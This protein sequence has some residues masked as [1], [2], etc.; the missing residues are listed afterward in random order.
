[1]YYSPSRKS[2]LPGVF[3]SAALC[4]F[5]S[6][7]AY[8]AAGEFQVPSQLFSESA[9]QAR[10]LVTRVGDT[11]GEVAVDYATEDETAQAG[12]DYQ[13]ASG[14]LT[15]LT[16]ETNQFFSVPLFNNSL[17]DSNRAFIVVLK[18]PQT[19]D[20][21]GGTNVNRIW[22]LDNDLAFTFDPFLWS[23]VVREDLGVLRVAVHRRDDGTNT[24]NV[25]FSTRAAWNSTEMTPGLDYWTTTNT[26][27][28]APGDSVK[29]VEV[30]IFNDYLK[31]KNEP[32]Y[33]VLR[34]QGSSHA[35]LT[36]FVTVYDAPVFEWEGP[37]RTGDP[38]FEYVDEG[39]QVMFLNVLRNPT[40]VNLNSIEYVFKD[41][42]AV[43]GKDY[44][45]TNGVLRF[46]PGELRK[47]I[48]V[49]L[50]N[51]AIKDGDR[52]FSVILT[53]DMA[54]QV[55]SEAVVNI[56]DDDPG[57][58]FEFPNYTNSWDESSAIELILLRGRTPA[59]GNVRVQYATVDGTALA[60]R[61]F[62]ATSGSLEFA[63]GETMKTIKVP[64]LKGRP[65]EG[66][67]EFSLIA[68][69]T[70]GVL[71]GGHTM[72]HLEGR[73]STVWSQ[74]DQ[75]LSV[76]AE[77][78]WIT[79][80][81][82]GEGKLRVSESPL[83]P[84][85]NI[86][87][88][89]SPYPLVPQ[90]RQQY[91]SVGST[92]PVQIFVPGTQAEGP[93]PLILV[94]HGLGQT[95]ADLENYLQL[96]RLA[97]QHGVFLCTPQ[98]DFRPASRGGISV[99]SWNAFYKGAEDVGTGG[100]YVDDVQWL[101]NMVAEVQ[102]RFNIDPKRVFVLGYDEGGSMAYRLAMERADL[103]AG[104]AS[105]AG[106]RPF[107]YDIRTPSE[108]VSVLH[109]HGTLDDIMPYYDD[110][111]GPWLLYGAE[112]YTALWAKLNGAGAAVV[113]PAGPMDLDLAVPGPETTVT[114][115]QSSPPGGAVELWTLQ[116]SG[117]APLLSTNSVTSELSA[118][119]VEWLL[120]HPK[121]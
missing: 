96:E 35:M 36:T 19:G 58:S 72:V 98:G 20:P 25:V 52:R 21:L 41:A 10:V 50:L 37:G 14:R 45:G 88:A 11:T 15:F 91:Y 94:L 75:S 66:A 44:L 108:P 79:F 100:L 92:R 119:V 13:S 62:V 27:V 60:G 74:S 30:P 53:N 85:R 2:G 16:G 109:L 33:M 4:A 65:T 68:S 115:Y 120:S 118:K 46:E 117:H 107:M 84:W 24:Q 70:S 40:A 63:E 28:F 39:A 86:Q 104:L 106:T 97:D 17:V 32:L 3:A 12:V 5:A 110:Q 90:H 77:Q 59:T 93:K 49:P 114:R 26:L 43:N 6:L 99:F 9:G 61:D 78:G 23:S 102:A 55:R 80:T 7:S 76:E 1:M 111:Y 81:W 101:T 112:S 8:G 64:L 56:V 83:G 42:T 57:I 113:D 47:R 67:S 29:T 54:R 121:P 48:V 82:P 18:D 89:S 73:H 22:I 116:G 69:D 105:I 51:N 87:T 31:E 38:R 95:D 103:V 34:Q 71:G